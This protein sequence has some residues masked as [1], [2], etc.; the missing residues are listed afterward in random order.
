LALFPL[1]L[2]RKWKPETDWLVLSTDEEDLVGEK[3]YLF[4]F[5]LRSL[6]DGDIQRANVRLLVPE[7]KNSEINR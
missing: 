2:I 4:W 5:P 3:F 1:L 6:V 7:G